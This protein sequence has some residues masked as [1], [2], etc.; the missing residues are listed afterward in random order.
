MGCSTFIQMQVNMSIIFTDSKEPNC[1]VYI[2]CNLLTLQCDRKGAYKK[3]SKSHKT[4]NFLGI[5]LSCPSNNTQTQDKNISRSINNVASWRD[6]SKHCRDSNECSY[7]TW[8]DATKGTFAFRCHLLRYVGR[9]VGNNP[10]I[11]SGG[12]DC[13]SMN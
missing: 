5:A 2:A 10:G 4:L 7:W 6:C 9:I 8:H 11:I 12:R 13:G 3:N 1:R